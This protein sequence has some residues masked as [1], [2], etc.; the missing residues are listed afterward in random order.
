MPPC[1]CGA[2]VWSTCDECEKQRPVNHSCPGGCDDITC[3]EVYV[4]TPCIT[5]V[6]CALHDAD[7]DERWDE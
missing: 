1:T 2:G 4:C 6:L 3:Q 7:E 5:G